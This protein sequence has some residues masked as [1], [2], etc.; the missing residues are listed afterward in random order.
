MNVGV[1]DLTKLNPAE[2][3]H[4]PSPKPAPPKILAAGACP[5]SLFY[6]TLILLFAPEPKHFL[7]DSINLY[8]KP[9]LVEVGSRDVTEF[10]NLRHATYYNLSFESANESEIIQTTSLIK[11]VAYPDASN[12]FKTS[13]QR[14]M[15]VRSN[16]ET[17][18]RSYMHISHAE[19]FMYYH[20]VISRA[21]NRGHLANEHIFNNTFRPE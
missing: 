12:S 13:S 17:V 18:F 15:Q 7:V 3:I 9:K 20:S 1:L 5:A 2:K 4:E 19:D 8:L 16:V 6:Q 11:S 10:H 21:Y 14:N